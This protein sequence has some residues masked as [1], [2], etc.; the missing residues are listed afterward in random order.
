[1]EDA[2]YSGSLEANRAMISSLSQVGGL[3]GMMTGPN[4]RQIGDQY[5]SIS[6]SSPTPPPADGT[7]VF[8]YPTTYFPAVTSSSA[9]IVV[10]VASAQERTGVDLHV[11]AVPTARI[12][13]TVVGTGTPAN[14]PLKLV[15][16]NEDTG[17]QNDVAG[18]VTDANGAFTFP[19]VPAGEYTLKVVQV[20]R[21]LAPSGAVTTIQI[22]SGMVVSSSG[23]SPEPPPIPQEP[24]L[25][26]SVPV[27]VG[28][29]DVTNLTVPLRNGVRINGRVD[30]DGAKEK[31]S[32]DALSRLLVV[33]EPVDGIVDRV[34]SPPGRVDA[35]GQFTTYGVAGGKYFVRVP[36]PPSGWT[37]NGAM[38]GER[39]LSDTP[40]DLDAADIA[41]V[42]LT[43]TDRPSSLSGSVQM[44]EAAARE[45]VAVVV[46]P[47]DSKAWMEGG[48]NPR[49]MRRV[50][51]T[52]AGTFDISP[53][54]P[55]A[56]YVAAIRESAGTDWMDPKFL[57]SLVAGA[58]HVQIEAGEKATQNL[59][60]L[61]AR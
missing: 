29:S 43:F 5:Q 27:S 44:N 48:A 49:R 61:E 59:R 23:P 50:A 28:D 13:G 17:R 22:G 18:T 38:L 15:P 8:A 26:A 10:T 37:F 41:D 9:A 3:G 24:T 53:L 47:A 25:W 52:D 39:D 20:P 45:G 2:I 58:A 40:I 55:G 35:K 16:Q 31:P 14:L 21:S 36:N 1:M 42:V 57:E 46:F 56:Y 11:K 30:F 6:T 7:R 34:S 4:S 54:P 32:P 33:V 51:T 12:S 60:V 19:V